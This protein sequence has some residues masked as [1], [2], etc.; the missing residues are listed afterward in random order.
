MKDENEKIKIYNKRSLAKSDT[1]LSKSHKSRKC[2]NCHSKNTIIIYNYNGSTTSDDGWC[3]KD[4]T[5]E[6]KCLSCGKYYSIENSG[7][8]RKFYTRFS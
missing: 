5:R 3:N 7:Y 4:Q 8:Y 6:F 2:V 1:P